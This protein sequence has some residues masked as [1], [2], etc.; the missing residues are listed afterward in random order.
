M[1]ILSWIGKEVVVNHDKDVPFRLLKKSK[2]K[3]VNDSENLIIEGDNLEALKALL[4]HY[5]N[6]IKCVFIDPPYNTGNEHWR[7]S[8]NVNSPTIKK[9][10]G[11]TVGI[12]DLTR[13]DKWL[14]MM[15]PRL[16]LLRQLLRDDGA[17]FVSINDKAVLDTGELYNLKLIMDEIF[18]E[19]NFLAN[20]IWQHS[21]QP[22]GY[23]DKFS[24]H[25]NHILCYQ[26]SDLFKLQ[27]LERSEKDNMNYSNPDN[28]P[29]GLWRTGDVRNSLYRKNL[30]F[31]I[32]T[33]SGKIIKPPMNGWRWSKETIQKKIEL[34]EIIFNKD[35]TRIIR[36]I[37][38]KNVEGRAPETIWFGND[39][40]T[41]RSA[42]QEIKNIFGKLV[43]ETPKPKELIKKIIEITSSKE[44]IIL[45]SFA[46][47]G[48]TAHA[49][50][51]LNKKDSGNR[52][53][54]LV[55]LE[56]D[57]CKKIT[58]ERVKKV[59]NGYSF[60][61]TEHTI[62]YQKKLTPTILQNMDEEFLDIGNIKKQHQ[63]FKKF[64]LE[65]KNNMLELFG[66]NKISKKIEGLGGGF[67]YAVLDKK[68]FHSDGRINDECTFNE[69]AS[70][71]YF[72]E[73]KTILDIKKIKKTLIGTLY[74]T[75]YHVIFDGIGK[76]NVTRKFLT[77]LNQYKNKVIYADKCTL[78]DELLKKYHTVFKQIPY[79]VK[80]F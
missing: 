58:S 12:E 80:I 15:Y 32:I 57:I 68:L 19:E 37:Y 63:K 9:W 24:I 1:T 36:K 46:G 41:T 25:H 70:Y 77:S 22:K 71:I 33:P 78:D 76:N 47:S 4:P 17:I 55:E 52:K 67:Q 56:S 34:K 44:D 64:K 54:I 28:D 75:E 11:T 8:D 18:Y 31:N 74:D 16:K 26:K 45:D 21:L 51:E 38:L 69:L 79:E 53:F 49:V 29:N 48:T 35:E 39:V 42:A 61:G 40:G 60:T 13:H 65:L 27:S 20:I 43:F 50:L 30:I 62:L 3:S 14:C 5:Q 6:K 10:L 66:E 59:I 23:T 72:I 73:T 2:S 7:Y